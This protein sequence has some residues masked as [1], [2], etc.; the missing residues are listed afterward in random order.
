MLYNMDELYNRSCNYLRVH[1]HKSIRSKM[2]N[3]EPAVILFWILNGSIHLLSLHFKTIFAIYFP[4][5]LHYI[6]EEVKTLQYSTL[7]IVYN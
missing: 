2:I 4:L 3:C 6:I 5:S 1:P 7:K